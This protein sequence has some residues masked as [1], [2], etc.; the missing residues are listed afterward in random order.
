MKAAHQE[1]FG[2]TSF[3]LFIILIFLFSA[4]GAQTVSLP[5]SIRSTRNIASRQPSLTNSLPS[6]GLVAIGTAGLFKS[7]EKYK[8]EVRDA[9]RDISDRQKCHVDDYVQYLPVVATLTLDRAGI[10][11]KHEIVDR[12][13]LSGTAYASMAS[14]TLLLKHTITSVRPGVY[15]CYQDVSTRGRINPATRPGYFNSFPSGHTA[16]AFTGAELVRLEYGDDCPWA[17]IGAYVVATGVG[18][19]RVYNEQHWFTDVL[20]GAGLGILSTR[21][22]WWMLPYEK[23]AIHYFSA[24]KQHGPSSDGEKE[25]TVYPSLIGNEPTLTLSFTF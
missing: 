25:V 18:F 1:I 20:A 17:A 2:I 12:A 5:D 8:L 7:A 3:A 14:I 23:R 19:L 11:S 4:V 22:G 21:I 10:A 13:L 24:D 16:T 6:F 15:D 9:M